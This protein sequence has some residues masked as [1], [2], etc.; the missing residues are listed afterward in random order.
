M[1]TVRVLR[2]WSAVAA[3]AVA[4]AGAAGAG[5]QTTGDHTESLRVQDRRRT[6]VVHVPPSVSA[7]HPVPLVIALHGRLGTGA[8]T[9]RLTH[10]D[11]VADAHGFVVV[12]PDG[13]R[14]S[15]ADGRGGTPADRQGVD[16]VAFIRALIDWMEHEYAIA[17]TRIYVTGIS[18][19][20]F[21][22]QRVG[23]ALSDRVAA[24]GVVAATMGQTIAATCRPAMPVSVM[25]V[26][27][28]ADPLVSISGGEV[29]G[30]APGAILSL[31]AAAD[32][33]IRLDRCAPAARTE[34]LPDTAR[35]RT[36]IERADYRAC[37]VG[38]EVVVY[39][40]RG[41][42]HAWPGGIQYLPVSVVGRASRNMD[43]SEVMWEFFSRH[44]R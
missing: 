5:A 38:S 28:T 3:G 15:W 22:T 24:I 37:S 41:G 43:A 42:G 26:Q 39:T 8:G 16:D 32:E 1:R 10:F 21:M 7:D 40:V 20:G 19:G 18:N 27:G 25:L 11:R 2:L 31:A 29:R 36:T 34:L 6:F 30:G 44:T 4:L 9:A 13:V 33:W 12:Y 17:A 14:R 23:C 35:D